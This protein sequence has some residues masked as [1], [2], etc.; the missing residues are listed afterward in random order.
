[1]GSMPAGSG[2]GVA[3]LR[4]ARELNTDNCIPWPYSTNGA[5]GRVAVH[6]KSLSVYRVQCTEIYGP[7][8]TSQH[9][10]RHSCH[11]R[12]C[13]N[14]RHLSWGTPGECLH[15]KI[16]PVRLTP[17]LV[18]S[19]RAEPK[20]LSAIEL[21]DKYD[22]TSTDDPLGAYR[23]HVEACFLGCGSQDLTESCLCRHVLER[24]RQRPSMRCRFGCSRGWPSVT[25]LSV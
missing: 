21:G 11:N 3:F 19:I 5:Y 25:R 24:M 2:K 1:M 22:V 16:G 4:A 9:W 14:P 13:V 18:R 17:E 6:G 15:N 8:P 20:Y 23:P 12:L 10:A 7:P